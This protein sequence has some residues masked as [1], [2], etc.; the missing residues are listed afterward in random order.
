MAERVIGVIGGSG[1]YEVQ[2]LTHVEEVRVETPFGDPSDLLVTGRI[3]DAKMVFL[4]R[5]G[6]GHRLNPSEVP[7]RANIWAMKSLGVQWIVSLSAVGSLKEEI[8]PGHVVLVDQFVDR[9]K[10]IR[11]STF[12]E[13]GIVA[14]VAFGDPVSRVLRGVLLEAAR[15]VGATVH[16]GGAYVCMEGPAFSTQAESHLYRSWGA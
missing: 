2:E 11:P 12:F 14:H 10:G 8:H 1:L 4:P 5:H 13:G 16:D 6:R 3:G 15:E 9:T 7:Y